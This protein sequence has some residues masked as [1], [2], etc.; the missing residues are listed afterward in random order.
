[1]DAWFRAILS[2][3]PSTIVSFARGVGDR[4]SALFGWLSR[5]LGNAYVALA[6]LASVAAHMRGAIVNIA[7]E[8][9]ATLKWYITV[10]VPALVKS[11]LDSAVRVATALVN[12][13][14]VEYKALIA[15]LDRWVKLA[16][17]AVSKAVTDL[18]EW[19][20]EQVNSIIV[21]LV[22]VRDIVYLLLTSPTR[23]ASWLVAAMVR[24][25]WLYADRNADRIAMWARQKSVAF[26]VDMAKRIEQIIGRLL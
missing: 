22:K 5:A 3:A 2:L 15:T 19:T 10:R 21:T 14:K 16:V 9:I 13:A 24:E 17:S 12:A 11:A 18:R 1:M 23:L 6:T 26:T 7:R 8:I 25:I 4:F 20:L